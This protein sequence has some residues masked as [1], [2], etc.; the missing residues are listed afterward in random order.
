MALY[1]AAIHPGGA[2]YMIPLEEFMRGADIDKTAGDRNST[3][4]EEMN[5]ISIQ[6]D[7]LTLVAR[8]EEDA[9]NTC[10]LFRRIMPLHKFFS[11]LPLERR[12]DVGAV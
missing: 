12:I 4:K 3:A 9:P 2:T 5:R 11:A 10:A 7:H 8:F 1:S 6:V